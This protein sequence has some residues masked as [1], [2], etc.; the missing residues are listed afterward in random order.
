[1]SKLISNGKYE[2]PIYSCP[3][4]VFWPQVVMIYTIYKENLH[5]L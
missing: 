1:M 4:I 3:Y 2:L 5:N